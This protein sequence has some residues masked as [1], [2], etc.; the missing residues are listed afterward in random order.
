M[1]QDRIPALDGMRGCAV[2]LVLCWHYIPCQLAAEPRS[3]EAV[4][5]RI[6]SLTYTGVDLFFVL[7]GFLI[8][9][10][11]LDH[12][13]AGN[14]FRVFYARRVCRIFPLYFLVLGLFVVLTAV[15]LDQAPGFEWL[16]GNPLPL[17]SY[18]TFT[19]NVPMGLHHDFGSQWLAP[20]WSLAVEEQFY[21]V[22]P[23]LVWLLPRRRLA[24]VALLL[25]F[26]AP[27]LRAACGWSRASAYV[28]TPCR[29]DALLTGALLAVVVRDRQLLA[30]L[31]ANRALLYAVFI[32]FLGVV[33]MITWRPQSFGSAD[34]SWFA[35]LYGTFLL[36]A[37]VD[38][39]TLVARVLRHRALIWLGITSY[40]IY[41]FH[42]PVSGLVHGF[43]GDGKPAINT[44]AGCGLTLLAL[45]LTLVTAAASYRFFERPFLAWGHRFRYQP[46]AAPPAAPPEIPLDLGVRDLEPTRPV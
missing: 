16:L 32:G 22:V 30:L 19:Q 24:L 42:Q 21:L 23:L 10:I 35:G 6:F 39:D 26:L 46:A 34:H 4:V 17:W 31:R 15:G 45:A 1:K 8:A 33:A 9:G 44:A 13:D 28:W 14:Y 12:R 38:D 7:S 11:L 43:L 25:I 2:V 18:A 3:M 36:L 20:T 37:V 40:G 29:N 41:L 5:W 27:V